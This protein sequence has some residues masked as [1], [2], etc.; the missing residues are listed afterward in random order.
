MCTVGKSSTSKEI[1]CAIQSSQRVSRRV[2][3]PALHDA[4]VEDESHQPYPAQHDA[5]EPFLQGQYYPPAA[6]K[7]IE[8]CIA[9]FAF[10]SKQKSFIFQLYH[11]RIFSF[12]S[13]GAAQ[14]T[15]HSRQSSSGL[16]LHPP[17]QLQTHTYTQT[18]LEHGVCARCP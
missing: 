15:Q 1:F 16:Q 13:S 5:V 7:F 12:F 8:R 2:L 17:N 9:Q 14:E 6:I 18:H 10:L 11:R 3:L 4:G